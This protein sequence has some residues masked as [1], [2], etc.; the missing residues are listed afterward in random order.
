VAQKSELASTT[1]QP[2]IVTKANLPSSSP[3]LAPKIA[4]QPKAVLK[5][6]LPPP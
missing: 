4:P 1:G 5:I 6:K 3:A 2:K